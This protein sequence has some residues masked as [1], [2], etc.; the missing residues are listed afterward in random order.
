MFFVFLPKEDEKARRL[1]CGLC[2]TN[3]ML[4]FMIFIKNEYLHMVDFAPEAYIF[5]LP[6]YWAKED[7]LM[8]ELQEKS[9]LRT[10]IELK[11]RME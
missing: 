4:I 7:K 11:E 3:T 9:N 10:G 5:C 1:L 2:N 6:E 8:L